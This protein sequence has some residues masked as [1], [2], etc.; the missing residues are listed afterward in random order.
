MSNATKYV[1]MISRAADA[2]QLDDSLLFVIYLMQRIEQ[3]ELPSFNLYLL[4][5]IAARIPDSLAGRIADDY[6]TLYAEE[7]CSR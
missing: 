7:L 4:V 5:V 3:G 1:E 6:L 2:A